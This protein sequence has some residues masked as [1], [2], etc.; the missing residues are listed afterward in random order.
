MVAERQL[1][2]LSEQDQHLASLTRRDEEREA[3]VRQ[4][5]TQVQQSELAQAAR[6]ASAESQAERVIQQQQRQHETQVEDIQRD[7]NRRITGKGKHTTTPTATP[8]KDKEPR[9]G[10]E[11]PPRQ[12]PLPPSPPFPFNPVQ[13]PPSDTGA[14]SSSSAPAPKAKAKAKAMATS[15]K[16]TKKE[17][18]KPEDP[19]RKTRA[20]RSS[21]PQPTQAAPATRSRSRAQSETAAKQLAPSV[22]GIQKLREEMEQA[23]IKIS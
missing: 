12:E 20:G 1:R 19:P 6:L 7:A 3:E 13:L 21:S 17:A 9:F 2:L 18:D 15:R 22:I 5:L 10:F 11:T 14:S 8:Q 23:K 16:G 4:M